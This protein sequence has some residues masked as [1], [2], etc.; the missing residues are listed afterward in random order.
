MSAAQAEFTSIFDWNP[1]RNRRGVL[2]GCIAGSA[3]LHAL[4]FYIF[5]IIYPPTIALLPP[6]AHINIIT[7]GTEDGRVLLRW[8]EAE[9]PALSSMTQRAPGSLIQL[10]AAEYI[11]SFA[12]HQPT[13]RELPANELDLRMP[14]ARPPAPVPRPRAPVTPTKVTVATTIH[15]SD[16]DSL[17]TP[18]TPPL[19]FTASHN[20]P[21]Q[22]AEFRIGI[23]EH[24]AVRHCF[25]ATSSGDAALDEQARNILMRTRFPH[26][27]NQ[28]SKTEN[29]LT[30]T[31]ATIDWGN[32]FAAPTQPTTNSP[33]P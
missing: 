23:G 1:P 27:R 31:R 3:I 22:S 18:E 6:P 2:I 15:F 7:S 29:P 12:N 16:D 32:D 8:I 26:G 11:P 17:G 33:A 4:C 9:D 24:G 13:L 25:L 28:N 20:E 14:S 5:Q 21:P 19:Q 10:P 30:W